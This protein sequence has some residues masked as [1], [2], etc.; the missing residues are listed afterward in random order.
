MF[1]LF[2]GI[3]HGTHKIETM[4]KSA[5]DQNKDDKN[6]KKGGALSNEVAFFAGIDWFTEIFFF[7]GILCGVCWW[8]F[9]KFCE[10]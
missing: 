9:N 8:E 6:G 2:A 5:D 10:S 4:M 3:G 7:Y 1:N